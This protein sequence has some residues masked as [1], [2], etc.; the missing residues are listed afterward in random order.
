MLK[1]NKAFNVN[2]IALIVSFLFLFTSIAYSCPK[3]SLRV[4]V[5]QGSTYERIIGAM[6]SRAT[7]FEALKRLL[8]MKGIDIEVWTDEQQKK[9]TQKDMAALLKALKAIGLTDMQIKNI[10]DRI[11]LCEVPQEIRLE[12]RGEKASRIGGIIVKTKEGHKILFPRDR[13]KDMGN[14]QYLA[15]LLHEVVELDLI[16]RGISVAIA[17]E[18]AIKA[19]DDFLRGSPVSIAEIGNKEDVKESPAKIDMSRV[20]QIIFEVM[21]GIFIIPDNL[22]GYMQ[23]NDN[24]DPDSATVPPYEESQRQHIVDLVTKLLS[25]SVPLF[26]SMATEGKD[27]VIRRMLTVGNILFPKSKFYKNGNINRILHHEIF[28][29]I[30][31]ANPEIKAMGDKAFRTLFNDGQMRFQ[32]R[33]MFQES[34]YWRTHFSDPDEFWAQYFYPS[35]T[36]SFI[37]DEWTELKKMMTR[38]ISGSSKEAKDVSECL[39]KLQNEVLP[40]VQTQ[41]SGL[42]IQ[43]EN[44]I[45]HAPKM[46]QVIIPQSM[47]SASNQTNEIGNSAVEDKITGA[48]HESMVPYSYRG[49]NSS[50]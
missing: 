22:I 1:F 24:I 37:G 13:I 39:K 21:P 47:Q 31:A 25:D 18:T 26:N 10:S 20:D 34:P 36:D 23:E 17:H 44:T 19:R 32:L 7:R 3:D 9:M 33:I 48:M 41:A 28:H 43:M 5:A 14:K 49:V 35:Y 46:A 40:Q 30:Y 27:E 6:H 50:L 15:D 4:P 8:R 16:E 45:G 12:G 29:R 11:I 42:L 38:L 2:I